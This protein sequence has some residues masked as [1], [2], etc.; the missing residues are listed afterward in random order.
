MLEESENLHFLS[1]SMDCIDHYSKMHLCRFVRNL[2]ELT[3]RI[4]C[5]N[6]AKGVD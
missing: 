4:R 2:E 6:A 3:E 5:V 1:E